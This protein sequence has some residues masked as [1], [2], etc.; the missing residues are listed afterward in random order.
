VQVE[1]EV[2]GTPEEIW[3]AIATAEGI[4]SWFVPARFETDANGTPT[5]LVLHFGPGMDAEK[6]VTGWDPPRRFSAEGELAPGAPKMATEWIV[7]GRAGGTCTVRVVHNLFASTDDWDDQL[8]GMESGWPEFFN[9]LRL[10]LT[11]FRGQRCASF[12]VM[13]TSSDAEPAMWRSLA[14]AMG[15]ANAAP[16]SR[17]ATSADAPR[18]AGIVESTGIGEDLHGMVLRVNE[19]AA[20]IVSMGAH[21]MGGSACAVFNFY[22]Y[23]ERAAAAAAQQQREWAEWMNR[24]LPAAVA[25]P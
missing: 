10:W 19:P 17:V 14:A 12:Y 15:L 18:L 8:E 13:G 22:F 11:H 4:S 16:G 20:G 6:S 1:T 2:T 24:Q 3:K 23:G 9:V 21:T 5:K 7:E 25:A